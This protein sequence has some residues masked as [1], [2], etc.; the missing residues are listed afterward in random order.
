MIETAPSSFRKAAP[1]P[2]L[3]PSRLST[4]RVAF[5]GTC[6][7][8]GQRRCVALTSAARMYLLVYS[9]PAGVLSRRTFCG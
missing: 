7:V 1:Y 8:P 2:K 5:D 9:P 4:S 6:V 3:S